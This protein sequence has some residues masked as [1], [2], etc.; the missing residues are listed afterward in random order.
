MKVT[1]AVLALVAIGMIA[2]GAQAALIVAEDFDAMSGNLKGQT[3]AVG[4]GSATWSSGTQVGDPGAGEMSVVGGAVQIAD[5]N[6]DF[7]LLLNI[8]GALGTQND[9]EYYGF[10][11]TV[12][13]APS[14]AGQNDLIAA[15]AQ[16]TTREMRAKLGLRAGS[17]AGTFKLD[18]LDGSAGSSNADLQIGT[19][20]QVIVSRTG[21]KLWV[22]A[23]S[24][25][26]TP[27]GTDWGNFRT[28]NYFWMQQNAEFGSFT[29][30]R[31]AIGTDFDEVRQFIVPEPASLMMLGIGALVALRRRRMRA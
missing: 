16:E 30:D 22:N 10:Q 29:I 12:T 11:L 9:V 31:L 26:D 23:T 25:S 24:S 7:G 27:Y 3:T 15:L 21:Q 20:Y 6:S 19:T 1:A 14:D 8:T 28:P 17:T 5:T 2:G 18:L 13:S 4:T